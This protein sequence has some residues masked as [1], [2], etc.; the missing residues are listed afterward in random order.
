MGEASLRLEFI[1][2]P[3]VPPPRRPDPAQRADGE[4]DGPERRR[5]P[6]PPG[7]RGRRHPPENEDHQTAENEDQSDRRFQALRKQA[8]VPALSGLFAWM[9]RTRDLVLEQSPLG[10]AIGY[11]LRNRVALSR[12][13]DD[14][15]LPIDNNSVERSLRRIAL[16]RNNWGNV[17]NEDGGRRAAVLYSLVQT[18]REIGVNPTEYFRD[19]LIRARTGTDVAKLTPH[20][21]KTHF[22]AEVHARRQDA[23]GRITFAP[24]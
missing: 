15:R 3:T 21:W 19:V 24:R 12:Y 23:L 20:G 16:G 4:G 13:L 11:A 8:S 1:G 18:C 6:I 10:Q 22:M 17:G 9:E 7:S 14:G 2:Q 5:R